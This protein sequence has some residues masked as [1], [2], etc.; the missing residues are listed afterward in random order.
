MNFL[1]RVRAV[2]FGY[3]L[4][5][6][7]VIAA[8]GLAYDAKIH[9]RLAPVY[10]GIKTSTISQ[11]DLFR[12]EAWLAVVAAV[13]VLAIRRPIFAL[14]AAAVAGG[15][16]VPLVAYRYYDIGPIGPLPSMYEPVW[17]PDKTNTLWAQAIAT[18]ASLLLLVL[19]VR[20]ARNTET[21][22]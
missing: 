3:V 22:S 12:I 4:I 1:A 13:L 18:V 8:A 21:N 14:V 10:D 7:Q 19:L 9:F 2:R 20:R 15:G 16:I 17:Y 5:V 11:G 6:L